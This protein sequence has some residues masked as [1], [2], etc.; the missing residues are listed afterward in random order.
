M[1]FELSIKNFAIIEDLKVQFTKGLNLI[2]GETGSGK[3]I[4]IEALGMILGGRGTKDSIRT[5]N[6]K[7]IL[8]ATFLIEDI[9]RIKPILY[10]Y[11]I[12]IDKDGLLII[13]REI[14]INHPTISRINGRP[15]TLNI[16]NKISSH[17]VDI[18]AQNEHQS[19]LNIS[20][21]RKL[22][23]SFGD[24][25][26]NNLQKMIKEAYEKY[27]E[28]KKEFDNMAMDSNQREREIDLLKFQIN[29]IDNACLNDEDE[30]DI[31]N[32]FNKLNNI[33]EISL[34][35]GEI[36]ESLNSSNYDN[37]TVIDY[38]NRNVSILSDLVKFDQGL[39]EYLQK[40]QDISYEL[41]D[42]NSELNHYMGR[43]DID[44]ERLYILNER[45]NLI[46]KLKKKYGNSIKEIIR[47]RE[48]MNEN[49]Q[50][51]LNHENEVQKLK[52]KIEHDEKL[53]Y[54]LAH[55]LSQYR[56]SI[57]LSLEKKIAKE[58]EDLSMNDVIFKVN[59]VESNNLSSEGID[60]VEF[61]I[62]TNSGEELK[63][64][65]RIVSGGEMSRIMLGFKS[66]L[67]KYDGIPTLVFDEIDTG[68]SG[69]TAQVVGEKIYEISKSHQVILI[70][71][72][73]QIAALA[74]SHYVISKSVNEKHKVTANVLK[75]TDQERIYELGRLLGGFNV[76]DTTLKH[77]QE[78]L[79]MSKIIKE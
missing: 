45:L 4:I 36:I 8:Q 12:D 77:A 42:L 71:H 9:S 62:S 54:E 55:N 35:L 32:E 57:S 70:S 17:L 33:K 22:I 13:S 14:S 72:L 39:K 53:I 46:N 18:F 20:N 67:A 49:L 10:E 31:E 29:E 44:E 7:A 19:L 66:I 48:S 28:I 63:S 2:T 74:D 58:L 60:Q 69:R 23:D 61:L 52:A 24:K 65:S 56:K 27:I 43:M 16:L 79:E 75:L 68:I 41:Q 1:L 64:L 37:N 40:M 25:D 50:K 47:Y 73:P 21:H 78:M 34:G 76:T 3:S 11:G 5:G 51:L 30:E 38:I 59:I 15:V 6:D 26:F